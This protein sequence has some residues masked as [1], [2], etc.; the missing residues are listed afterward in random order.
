MGMI[1]QPYIGER[2]V[3]GFGRAEYDGPFGV[4]P[5]KTRPA[6]PL[7]EATIL[8][9]FPEVGTDEEGRAFHSVSRRWAADPLWHGIAMAMR[10][11][12]LDKSIW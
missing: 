3:G 9:T 5:L 10:C 4:R 8:T 1:D 12:P 6:R 2:F 7:S 11:W